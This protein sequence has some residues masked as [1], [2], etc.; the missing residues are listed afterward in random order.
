MVLYN[1]T[2]DYYIAFNVNWAKQLALLL[3]LHFISMTKPTFRSFYVQ[4]EYVT[5]HLLPTVAIQPDLTK[6]ITISAKISLEISIDFVQAVLL[7]VALLPAPPLV[8]QLK[9]NVSPLQYKL[10]K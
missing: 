6:I 3:I 8:F 9:Y 5:F 4:V 1:F 10:H 7:P 2:F